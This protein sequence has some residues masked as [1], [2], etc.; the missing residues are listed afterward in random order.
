MSFEPKRRNE[1]AEVKEANCLT[2]ASTLQRRLLIYKIN[3]SIC[4]FRL[5]LAA[6]QSLPGPKA[7]TKYK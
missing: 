2:A 4:I 6:M 7:A 5:L 1:C 3:Q